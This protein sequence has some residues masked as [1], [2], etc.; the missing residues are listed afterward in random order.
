M[1]K[2]SIIGAI[3]LIGIGIVFGVILVSNFHG[4]L[5]SGFAGDPQVQLGAPTPIKTPN[6]TLLNQSHG[7]AQV[8][9]VVTPTVVSINVTM[10]EKGKGEDMQDFFHFFGP[11]F[12]YKQPEP[13][14]GAGSGFI[15]T[16]TGYILTNN[17]VVE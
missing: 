10:K 3:F 17:H 9:K 7:F 14:Q 6:Q 13:E 2:R 4:G 16:P 5:T 11:D 1:S 12:K 15:I 8:A